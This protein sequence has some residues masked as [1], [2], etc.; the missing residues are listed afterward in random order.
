[1]R[2][3]AAGLARFCRFWY[4]KKF[5]NDFIGQASMKKKNKVLMVF[6]PLGMSGSFVRHAPISLL[7]ASSR[8]VK[9]GF[10][11]EVFDARLCA[12]TWREELL[13]RL[14]ESVLLV[15]VSVMTGAAGDAGSRD[16]RGRKEP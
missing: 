9:L 12:S 4:L 6:P 1:M 13:A 8:L 11:V 16:R 14:D 10:E 3:G 5:L 7:Y 15:G 2:E